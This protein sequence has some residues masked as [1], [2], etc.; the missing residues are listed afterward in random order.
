MST[1]RAA[2]SPVSPSSALDLPAVQTHIVAIA[3]TVDDIVRRT[4]S[5][6]EDAEGGME[7]GST[8]ALHKH[9]DPVLQVLEDCRVGL[10]EAGGEKD[11][12]RGR[13]PGLAFRLARG[14]KVG[15]F[16]CLCSFCSW[17]L[18]RCAGACDARGS[19]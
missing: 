5:A 1:I 11:G 17:L 2:S 7:N 10:L 6:A 4:R 18:M 16:L 3:A 14:T 13:V 19:D 9:A 15:F 12:V 8:A